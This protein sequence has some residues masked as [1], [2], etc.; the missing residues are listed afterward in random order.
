MFSEQ[1]WTSGIIQKQIA[2]RQSG[3]KKNWKIRIH[4]TKRTNNKRALTLSFSRTHTHTQK[5]QTKTLF[6]WP[7]PKI[8]IL[9]INAAFLLFVLIQIIIRK[10]DEQ[11]TEQNKHKKSSES[12][13]KGNTQ[14]NDKLPAKT[15]KRLN[16]KHREQTADLFLF[17]FFVCVWECRFVFVLNMFLEQSPSVHPK[18][19]SSLPQPTTPPSIFLSLTFFPLYGRK[20]IVLAE[21]CTEKHKEKTV[22]YTRSVVSSYHTFSVQYFHHF[23]WFTHSETVAVFIAC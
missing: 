1:T 23:S 11:K 10:Y 20:T 14:S 5:L 13:R 21:C 9:N 19:A 16:E 2:K 22:I 6:F 8:F 17:R 4:S 7:P 3:L 18:S 12:Q 15:P